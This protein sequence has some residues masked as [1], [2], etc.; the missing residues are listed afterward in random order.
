MTGSPEPTC[1][2][3]ATA[4]LDLP[5]D[6]HEAGV[7]FWSAATGYGASPP[8]GAEGEFLTLLPPH[9]DPF[10]RVQRTGAAGAPPAGPSVHLDLHVTSADDAAHRAAGL[11]A[12]VVARPDGPGGHVVMRSP[13]GF[14]FCF[15]HERLAERPE[16]ARW[17]GGQ[18]SIA[19]QVCLDIPPDRNGAERRFWAGL[20]GWR[21]W[22]STSRPEFGN[23]VGPNGM[24]IRLLLQ[25]LDA[26][27]DVVT[28]HLDFACDHRAAEVARHESIG[29]TVV[30]DP[31]GGW[32]VLRDP[33]GLRYC[34]TD[35]HPR[36]RPGT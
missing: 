8:R 4:F 28:A 26:A 21:G 29:A 34:V 35:R 2:T 17:P 9:G 6:A 19:G 15:V 22:R 31:G 5:P 20:T 36:S 18:E 10:L 14:V 12:A 16:P 27:A 32:T 13:G 7:A 11:G 1:I 33:A 23:L 3:W 25:R 30:G 24:S